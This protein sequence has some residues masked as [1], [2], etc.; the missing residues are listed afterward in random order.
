MSHHGKHGFPRTKQIMLERKK[1][2]DERKA[3]YDKLS[4]QQKLDALPE[5]KCNR[6]RA[7]YTA[8]LEKQAQ[9]QAPVEKTE[10]KAKK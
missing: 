10:K 6:Q 9:K 8:M 7:R 4:L 1:Q 2:A 3:E 5:G